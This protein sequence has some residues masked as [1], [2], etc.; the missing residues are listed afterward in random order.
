MSDGAVHRQIKECTS[1]MKFQIHE[2]IDN[3]LDTADKITADTRS[4]KLPI[5]TLVR[6][7]H[8]YFATTLWRNP[9]DLHPVAVILSL[10]AHMALLAAL[11]VVMSGHVVAAF[12][13]LRMALESACYSYLIAK[14][15]E[16][17]PIW[18]NRHEGPDQFKACR[19]TFSSAVIDVSKSIEA[20]SSGSGAWIADCYDAS[21]DFGGHPNVKSVFEHIS[22]KNVSVD[23]TYHHLSLT[24]L[25]SANHW[26]T[27]RSLLACAEFG[28]AIAQVSTL[29]LTEYDEQ[30][31][32]ELQDLSDRKNAIAHTMMAEEKHPDA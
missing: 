22:I 8:R 18:T 30:H 20:D 28:L 6:D 4:Q 26:Q 21:I 5:L 1:I 15:P 3:Y 25:Y 14:N 19:K 12:P 29:M 24:G 23:D 11:R 9:R 17:G 27:C 10:N 32:T 16:L 13:V 2:S 31:E 7:L